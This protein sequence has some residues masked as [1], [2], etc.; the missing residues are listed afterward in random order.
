MLAANP[1]LK[2]LDKSPV[3]E[4]ELVEARQ[5]RNGR[6]EGT[7]PGVKDDSRLTAGSISVLDLDEA[8]NEE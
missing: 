3:L 7:L 4:T 8:Q 6:E 2:R 1:N 5:L